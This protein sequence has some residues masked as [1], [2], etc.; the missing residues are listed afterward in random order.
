MNKSLLIVG[1][2]A[3]SIGQS[4][5]AD[6]F[7]ADRHIKRGLNC[8]TC[9]GQAQL[10]KDVD[11]GTCLHCHG[12]TYEDLAKKTDDSD[13]NPLATHMGEISCMQCHQ[14]HARARLVCDQCHEFADM[15]K[16]P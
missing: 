14:G 10:N 12:P 1:L 4:M 7:L 15:F 2:L 3:C 11:F 5:A 16:V 8:Q 9:H 6:Q 13:I